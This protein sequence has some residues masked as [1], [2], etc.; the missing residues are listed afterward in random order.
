M[1]KRRLGSISWSDDGR[2]CRIRV[3]RGYRADGSPR[4]LTRTLHDATAD[5]AE[6]EAVRMAAELGATDLAGD[7][8]TLSSYYY[9]IFR[10]APSN[11]GKQRTKGTLKFYD[12][13]MEHYVLPSLGDLPLHK[14]THDQVASVVRGAASPKNCKTVLRAV[15]LAAYDDGFL[16]EKPFQRRVATP[17]KKKPQVQPWDGREVSLALKASQEWPR[18]LQA[19][20]ALGLS[21]LRK[22][23]A[24]AV[25]PSDLAMTRIYDFVTGQETESM[26][27]AVSRAYT[28]SDGLREDTKNDGSV[29]TV[30]VFAPCRQMLADAA[31]GQDPKERL[32]SYSVAA[33]DHRWKDALLAAGL[34]YVPPG[35]LRHTS[36]TLALDAGVAPDLVDKM[37]GRSE[38]T[39]TYRNYYRPA[40]SAMEQ[41]SRRVGDLI[42]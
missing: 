15:L 34:R 17:R 38:H 21:G 3:Q 25:R 40:L 26:T 20:L 13:A 35:M 32:V 36:D 16:A 5:E 2:R 24:L 6:A 7:S 27:V 39:S 14:I 12:Y 11:R 4:I 23:E 18:K 8:L 9:G 30:P 10:Q 33:L 1:P 37:H 42:D 22:S 31:V 28:A 41:A 19:Y 29:R